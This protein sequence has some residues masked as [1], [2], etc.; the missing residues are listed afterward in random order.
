MQVRIGSHGS[1]PSRWE[2]TQCHYPYAL[3]AAW[4]CPE[5]RPPQSGDLAQ[6]A[7]VWGYKAPL[8][9]SKWVTKHKAVCWL[10][11]SSAFSLHPFYY[12]WFGLAK[13]LFS[14]ENKYLINLQT[15]ASHK[16]HWISKEGHYWF[17]IPSLTC[18]TLHTWKEIVVFWSAGQPCSATDGWSENP[19]RSV[20]VFKELWA[21]MVCALIDLPLSVL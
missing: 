6:V 9:V 8:F 11:C 3:P 20:S 4:K 12:S 2:L 16:M 15:H 10:W 5:R 17:E 21:F 7:R 13:I 14:I 18:I 1:I 19:A